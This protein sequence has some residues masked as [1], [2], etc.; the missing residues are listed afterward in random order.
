[1]LLLDLHPASDLLQLDPHI[2]LATKVPHCA[3]EHVPGAASLLLH[4]YA[5]RRL[6]PGLLLFFAFRAVEHSSDMLPQGL[7]FVVEFAAVGPERWGLLAAGLVV[8]VED[9]DNLLGEPSQPP[10]PPIFALLALL[11]LAAVVAATYRRVRRIRCIHRQ[12]TAPPRH[13]CGVG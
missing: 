10:L 4:W 12:R 1:M 13:R 2:P 9:H 3:A 8:V 11:A 7:I 5:H 6:A